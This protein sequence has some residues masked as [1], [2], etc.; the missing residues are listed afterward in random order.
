MS[1]QID[2]AKYKAWEKYSGCVASTPLVVRLDGNDFHKLSNRCNFGKPFDRRFHGVMVGVA[3]DLMRKTGFN[4]SLAHTASDE[5]SLLFLRDKWLPHA[6][7]VEKILSLLAAYATSSFQYRLLRLFRYED[8]VSFDA[9]ILE[10]PVFNDVAE[11]FRWRGFAC[12]RNFLNAY[13]QTY[14]GKKQCMRMKGEQVVKEL[15]RVGFNIGKAPSWQRHGTTAYWEPFEKVGYNPLTRE[16][17]AVQRRRLATSV[18]DFTGTGGTGW[19]KTYLRRY[20]K[21]FTLPKHNS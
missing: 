18:V 2:E 3:K 9:R 20:E 14:I 19:L 6:G 7:R 21:G 11:Y 17:V 12:F 13:A 4:V 5:V 10:T 15:N 8:L 16:R 1:R